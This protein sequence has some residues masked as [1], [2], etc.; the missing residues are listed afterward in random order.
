MKP[1]IEIIPYDLNWPLLFK[2]EAAL[3][4]E[5]LGDNCIE[6]H[7]IGSTSVP[8]LAA[9]PIIDMVPVVKDILTVDTHNESMQKLGYNVRGE[10]GILFR[11]FFSKPGFNIHV[12][13][14]DSPEIDRHI[15]FRDWMIKHS[16]DVKR[17]EVLKK[18]LAKKFPDDIYKYCFGKDEFIAS[19]DARANWKGERIVVAVTAKEFEAYHRIRKEQIFDPINIVYDANHPA[20]TDKNHFHLVMYSGSQIVSVAHIEFLNESEAALRSLAIDS[21]F[22][23]RGYA[24]QMMQLLEKWLKHKK[25]KLFKMH[26]RLDAEA[27]YRKLGYE[28][29]KFDDQSIA[30][31]Y[32]DLGKVL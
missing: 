22:Q 32:I 3:I 15:K 8:G 14:V 20:M 16:A 28:D 30:E 21:K 27:F 13:E 5:A 18:E 31:R 29:C 11:R 4:K 24:K 12:F 1:T 6:I 26:A 17:Y 25:V 10:N 9:K 19:I 23:K 2:K 7:H